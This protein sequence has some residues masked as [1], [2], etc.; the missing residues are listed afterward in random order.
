[1]YISQARLLELS[2]NISS[3]ST[4]YDR[5][6]IF[7]PEPWTAFALAACSPV[8]PPPTPPIQNSLFFDNFLDSYIKVSIIG[9]FKAFFT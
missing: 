7:T 6:V 1:M 8:R 9:Q 5:F 4:V 2:G 3:A